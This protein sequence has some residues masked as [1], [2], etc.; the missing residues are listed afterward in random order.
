MKSE[1]V[2]A[3]LTTTL[4]ITTAGFSSMSAPQIRTAAEPRITAEMSRTE[5]A[6]ERP[7]CLGVGIMMF[8]GVRK[9]RPSTPAAMFPCERAGFSCMGCATKLDDFLSA[10]PLIS[11]SFSLASSPGGYRPLLVEMNRVSDRNHGKFGP[12]LEDLGR[13]RPQEMDACN[14]RLTASVQPT[15]TAYM[16]WLSAANPQNNSPKPLPAHVFPRFQS[17]GTRECALRPLFNSKYS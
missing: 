6:D 2:F 14:D 13:T 7:L 11:K 12:N 5:S 4:C 17:A 9:F 1:W 3:S 10:S 16:S 15:T 8:F